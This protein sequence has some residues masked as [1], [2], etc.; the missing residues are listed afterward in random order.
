[1]NVVYEVFMTVRGNQRKY[2]YRGNSVQMA[3]KKTLYGYA[4]KLNDTNTQ[5]NGN[6]QMHAS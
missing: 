3:G 1:M 5:T 6:D 4:E 2:G